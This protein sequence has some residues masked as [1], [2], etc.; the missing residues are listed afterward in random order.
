MKLKNAKARLHAVHKALN[1]VQNKVRLLILDAGDGTKHL[2]NM[3]LALEIGAAEL[4]FYRKE[5]GQ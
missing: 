3:A 4:D 2:G 5:T 1:H